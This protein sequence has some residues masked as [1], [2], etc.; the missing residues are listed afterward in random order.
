MEELLQTKQVLG[1]AVL[2]SDLSN[3]LLK[4]ADRIQSELGAFAVASIPVEALAQVETAE[5]A[6]DILAQDLSRGDGEF[7]EWHCALGAY[8]AAWHQL[9][10]TEGERLLG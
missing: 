1:E 9:M 7:T 5:D 2:L 3:D 8:E 10:T 6:L 4:V